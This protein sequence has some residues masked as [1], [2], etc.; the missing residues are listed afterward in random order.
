MVYG[1]VDAKRLEKSKLDV[2]RVVIL[3][4][5]G[6][7]FMSAPAPNIPRALPVA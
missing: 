1:E 5:S 4:G 7:G 6:A 3:G 2:S